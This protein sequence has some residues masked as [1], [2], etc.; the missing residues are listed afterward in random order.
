MAYYLI[1]IHPIFFLPKGDE[2]LYSI[3]SWDF[4]E[5]QMRPKLKI[6]LKQNLYRH[7]LILEKINNGR[8]F[9]DGARE[10]EHYELDE[11]YNLP[12][13]KLTQDM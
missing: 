2:N 1:S 11:Q 5:M 13:F 3:L 6:H 7:S 12:C 10:D 4:S 9:S 8:E